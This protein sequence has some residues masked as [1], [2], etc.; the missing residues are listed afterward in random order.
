MSMY[1]MVYLASF[2]IIMLACL[3][4]PSMYVHAIASVCHLESF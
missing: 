1:G 4:S 2:I 3:W